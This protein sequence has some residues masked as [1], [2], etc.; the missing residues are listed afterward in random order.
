MG[1]VTGA[2]AQPA[3]NTMGINLMRWLMIMVK[4]DWNNNAQT[5]K[6]WP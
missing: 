3:K 1:V 5:G 4:V 6:F 2:E